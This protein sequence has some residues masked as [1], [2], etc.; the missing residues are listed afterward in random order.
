V[1]WEVLGW[2]LARALWTAALL[3][4]PP[5]LVCAL[6]GWSA[7]VAAALATGAAV[8]LLRGRR[9]GFVGNMVLLALFGGIGVAVYQLLLLNRVPPPA[10]ALAG[11]LLPFLCFFVLAYSYAVGLLPPVGEAEEVA[12]GAER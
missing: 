10:A 4:L 2:S 7:A 8:T 11:L 3:A 1:D 9:S 5:L 6:F 12:G